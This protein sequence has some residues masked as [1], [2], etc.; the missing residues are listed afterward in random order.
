VPDQTEAVAE[1]KEAEAKGT[2]YAVTEDGAHI[3]FQVFGKGPPDLLVIMSSGFPV[4]DQMEGRECARLLRRLASFS[5]VI[6]MDRRGIGMSDPVRSFDE[7]VYERWVDDAIAVLDTVQSKQAAAFATEGPAGAPAMLLAATHPERASRLILHQPT[8]RVLQ[9]PDYPFGI[10]ETDVGDV[11]EEYVRSLVTGSRIQ[12]VAFHEPVVEGNE[13]FH[14]W[15]LRARRRGCPPAVARAIYGNWLRT[16]LRAVL[17]AVAVP[18]LVLDRPDAP[19]DQGMVRYVAEHIRDCRIA[20]LEGGEGFVFLGDIDPVIEEIEQFL[21]GVRGAVSTDRVLAT[22]LFT[23]IV[24]S[25]EQA[26]ALGDRAWGERLEDHD[27]VV[28]ALLGRF[29]GHEIK[30]TGD[31]FLATFDGPAR[32]VRCACGIRDG[33]RRLG[34]EVRAGLHAGEIERRGADIGGISVHIAQRVS[35]LARPGEV[36]VSRTV[37]DLVAGSGLSFQPRGEHELKGVA[38]SWRLFAV[39]S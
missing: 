3:A 18:T 27:A 12:T 7:H 16:D 1:A 9:A 10:A 15:F 13:E 19:G 14:S 8:A 2:E 17:P 20:R 4:E 36:L 5:R 37:T 32:A 29:R 24:G 23:D 11:V 38:E 30:T 33:A 28:R 26:S 22:V 6:R 31:G 21:T 34:I 35:S 39:E 25:T